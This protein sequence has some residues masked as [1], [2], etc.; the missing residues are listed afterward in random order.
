MSAVIE[1]ATVAIDVS[2]LL[3]RC[4]GKRELAQRVL[5]RFQK[6]LTDDVVSLQHALDT[7][8]QAVLAT[9]AHRVK[10]AAANVAAHRLHERAATLEEAARAG[11]WDQLPLE[12]ELLCA[13]REEFNAAWQDLAWTTPA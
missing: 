13:D 12:V 7:G 10:G 2:E 4:L 5:N 11:D 3:G 8:D 6:Q 1:Q 9:V